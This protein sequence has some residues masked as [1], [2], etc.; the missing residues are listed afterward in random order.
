MK[1]PHVFRLVMIAKV[2]PVVR[3]FT[4]CKAFTAR[5][6]SLRDHCPQF[7]ALWVSPFEYRVVVL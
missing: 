2:G 4:D 6:N 1:A 7:P 5:I 3:T